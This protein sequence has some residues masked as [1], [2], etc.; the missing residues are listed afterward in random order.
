MVKPRYLTTFE[1][2]GGALHACVTE[3]T[4]AG[5]SV[6]ALFACVSPA[7][8]NGALEELLRLSSEGALGSATQLERRRGSSG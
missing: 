6:V 7:A 3:I 1:D 2:V 8:G 5:A 4:P